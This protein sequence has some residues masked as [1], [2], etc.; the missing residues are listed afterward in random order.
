MFVVFAADNFC[1]KK[2]ICKSE[3]LQVKV[4][5]QIYIILPRLTH[6]GIYLQITPTA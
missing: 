4:V 1:R 2:G 3:Y 6:R 5:V